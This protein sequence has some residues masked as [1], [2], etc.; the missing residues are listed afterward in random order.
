M[1]EALK[2]IMALAEELGDVTVFTVRDWLEPGKYKVNIEG[3]AP[4]G[5]TFEFDV[6]LTVPVPE[7]K[8]SER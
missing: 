1:F 4:D 7:R 6:E 3:M 5:I 2:K 8:E